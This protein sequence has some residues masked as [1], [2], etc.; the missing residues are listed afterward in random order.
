MVGGISCTGAESNLNECSRGQAGQLDCVHRKDAGVLC[1]GMWMI[2]CALC[3]SSEAFTLATI[4]HRIQSMHSLKEKKNNQILICYACTCTQS[5]DST[6]VVYTVTVVT[7]PPRGPHTIGS[8]VNLTC[9]V[10][11]QTLGEEVTYHWRDYIPNISPVASNSSLPYATIS[12]GTGHPHTARYFCKVYYQNQ[13]LATG[14]TVIN[15]QG[16]S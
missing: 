10:H 7:D 4:P 15:V 8:T 11:P 1:Q 14:S 12:I 16:K 9:L 6:A 2:S 5:C 3:S 13:L